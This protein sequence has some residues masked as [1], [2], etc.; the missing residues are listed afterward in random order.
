M[1][2]TG[3]LLVYILKKTGERLAFIKIKA[4]HKKV[5]LQHQREIPNAPTKESAVLVSSYG[6]ELSAL[7]PFSGLHNTDDKI[8]IASGVAASSGKYLYQAY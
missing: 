5:S 2:L 8:Y 7:R 4:V 3:V 6:T 1:L